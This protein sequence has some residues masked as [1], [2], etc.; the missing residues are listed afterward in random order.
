[1]KAS[2]VDTGTYPLYYSEGYALTFEKSRDHII[3]YV[4]SDTYAWW[5]GTVCYL[6]PG[7]SVRCQVCPVGHSLH[8]RLDGATPP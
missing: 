7:R 2:R 3:V 6:P 5:T 1:M 4:Q 8:D